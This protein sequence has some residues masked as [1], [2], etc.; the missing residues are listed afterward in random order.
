MGKTAET[1]EKVI[2]CW[3]APKNQK[4]IDLDKPNVMELQK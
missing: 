2:I 4:I 3:A 1:N